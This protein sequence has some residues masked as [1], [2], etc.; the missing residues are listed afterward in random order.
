MKISVALCTYN[1]KQYINKQISS[2]LDQTVSVDEI[3]IC[4]DCSE[5]TTLL[6][7]K[8]TLQNSKVNYRILQNERT[9]GV[10]KNFEKAIS[11]C[12]GDLIFTADQD[13]IWDKCKVERMKEIFVKNPECVMA[14]SDAKVI[15]ENNNII[16]D[17][18][19][20]K[21]GFMQ[22]ELSEKKYVDDVV[23]LNYTIYG[24]TMAFR[25]SFVKE[26]MP[27]FET[28]ANHDAWIMCCAA[29]EGEVRYI[30]DPLISYRVHG[31]NVV[32]SICGNRK[33]E[34][35]IT[36]QDKFQKH[37]AMQELKE[38]RVVL[39][40]KALDLYP[41]TH[42]EYAKACRK[43]C[44]FFRR[45]EKMK[46]ANGFRRVVLLGISLIDG[47]YYYRFC[48]RGRK[49]TKKWMLKQFIYDFVFVLKE[50]N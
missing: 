22:G 30:P 16:L 31:K 7:V 44:C 43:M 50:G 37:F 9:L 14:F 48:D 11:Y 21:D 32:G 4:D 5:D 47:C 17:S 41:N 25:K 13:D 20:K 33:W 38:I 23:R 49:V 45:L 10:T 34:E 15:D 35:I 36:K 24:C 2:I 28:K 42:N 1:G 6:V 3:I 19:L 46:N 29:L 26:V 12:S 39:I 27:F 8:K 40:E 18:L